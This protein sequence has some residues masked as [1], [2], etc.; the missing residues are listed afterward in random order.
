ML[1]HALEHEGLIPEGDLD[2]RSK[3]PRTSPRVHG[4]KDYFK[5]AR[6]L[7]QK[8]H[9]T[10]PGTIGPFEARFREYGKPGKCAVSGM[11]LG[12]FG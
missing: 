6:K 3:S 5:E 9:G 12:A 8:Y 10:E 7:D 11:V 4:L 2:S 1:S